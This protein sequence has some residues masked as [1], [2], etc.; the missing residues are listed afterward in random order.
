MILSPKTTPIT[1]YRTILNTHVKS[2]GIS[3]TSMHTQ[4][5][6]HWTVPVSCYSC[7]VITN[8]Y[9]TNNGAMSTVI[10]KL[11]INLAMLVSFIHSMIRI[12][13]ATTFST[14]IQK[15]STSNSNSFE[16]I[17]NNEN[18]INSNSNINSSSTRNNKDK[19]N[20]IDSNH[21]NNSI[22][23]L[24]E[25]IQF[26][27]LDPILAR[28]YDS[29]GMTSALFTV[30]DNWS[31]DS[32]Y[33]YYNYYATTCTSSE[34]DEK[35]D[36]NEEKEEEQQ[37]N[38]RTS[39]S[40]S[41][42]TATAMA[43]ATPRFTVIV[44]SNIIER[45]RQTLLTIMTFEC[46]DAC[47]RVEVLPRIASTA[48][49]RCEL[50]SSS[51]SLASSSLPKSNDSNT[52]AATTIPAIATSKVTRSSS[53]STS[54]PAT[55]TNNIAGWFGHTT[56]TTIQQHKKNT[57]NT[58]ELTTAQDVRTILLGLLPG[59]DLTIWIET[60]LSSLAGKL[61]GGDSGGVTNTNTNTKAGCFSN[62][63][64][65]TTSTTGYQ[66]IPQIDSLV[67]SRSSSLSTGNG[68][69]GGGEGRPSRPTT[70]SITTTTSSTAAATVTITTSST[71]RKLKAP[72]EMDKASPI[73]IT[74]TILP[75]A[76]L[77]P[78][79]SQVSTNLS[80]FNED[81]SSVP[82][83]A[84]AGSLSPVSVAAATATTTTVALLPTTEDC[85]AGSNND[86]FISTNKIQHHGNASNDNDKEKEDHEDRLLLA[87]A[88]CPTSSSAG[89][90]RKRGR[91]DVGY[92]FVDVIGN[93][94]DHV[95]YCYLNEHDDDGLL[96]GLIFDREEECNNDSDEVTS[97]SSNTFLMP[98]FFET[99]TSLSAVS[100]L[101]TTAT[102]TE[103]LALTPVGNE[104]KKKKT[105]TTLNNHRRRNR[106]AAGRSI[107]RS[108]SDDD[109]DGSSCTTMTT[110]SS[111]GS[112]N[113]NGNSNDTGSGASSTRLALSSFSANITTPATSTATTNRHHH[114][115]HHRIH[116]PSSDDPIIL[117]SSSLLQGSELEMANILESVLGSLLVVP[118]DDDDYNN[119]VNRGGFDKDNHGG[120]GGFDQ[121]FLDHMGFPCP[122]PRE[123]L[124]V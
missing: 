100:T 94:G 102:T 1:N 101:V 49:F 35:Q 4:P 56:S 109:D 105:T 107:F 124:L 23:M 11:R 36:T 108:V 5:H 120:D 44:P 21:T 7:H 3:T 91:Y 78:C 13:T 30:V 38:T 110:A 66:D 77:I 83:S 68:V 58:I 59:Q 18:Y 48:A 20:N 28:K 12:P 104:T 118:D 86:N 71:A 17:N 76:A 41:S 70:Y 116:Q 46:T 87:L 24:I 61:C 47:E 16:K 89:P 80:S 32:A 45:I 99:K 93:D 103:V 60:C 43:T 119:N 97:N 106:A 81:I 31:Y 117:E 114:H 33:N 74:T 84:L 6:W 40:S 42:S 67:V 53:S 122:T 2:R 62:E 19:N 27:F 72:M 34:Q 96:S 22:S 26:R 111:S 15:R 65:A 52:P 95:H 123:L 10:L 115:H 92:S 90:P 85:D 55:T 9:G 8:Y 69:V 29:D 113:G 54:T 57:N 51:S 98:S 112:S 14:I 25:K 75:T 82:I 88:G 121:L 50:A 39:T 37:C 64:T 73:S 63:P 79:V